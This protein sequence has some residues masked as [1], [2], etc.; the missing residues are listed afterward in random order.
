MKDL[1]AKLEDV[2]ADIEKLTEQLEAVRVVISGIDK[3]INAG[4]AFMA[5]LR[6]NLRV[7]KLRNDIEATQAKIDS[8]DME[9][10][11]KA[12]RIF[13]EKY[14]KEKERE[15]ELQ[16]KVRARYLNGSLSHLTWLRSTLI[17]A[18]S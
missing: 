14:Q 4:D 1:V 2:Q 16:G 3:E 8:Y 6:E 10:A 5:N 13:T 15:G 7:R 17:L 18:E 12:K 9:E 11:A